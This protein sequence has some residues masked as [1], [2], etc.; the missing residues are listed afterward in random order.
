M[1][2]VLYT[3]YTGSHNLLVLVDQHAAHE[4]VRMEQLTAGLVT[5]YISQHSL[6]FPSSE[7]YSEGEVYGN[8]VSRCQI[9][10]SAIEP[11]VKIHSNHNILS[12]VAT[13]HAQLKTVGIDLSEVCYF[14]IFMLVQIFTRLMDR[15]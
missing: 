15:S 1:I 10:T 8:H 13:F 14:L 6:Y 7:L 5:Y 9:P 11:T 12:V 4:R 2:A 3:L